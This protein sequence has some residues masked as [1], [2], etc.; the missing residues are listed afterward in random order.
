[1][2]LLD[3]KIKRFFIPVNLPTRQAGRIQNGWFVLLFTSHV[4][5]LLL[6]WIYLN[7]Q[8]IKETQ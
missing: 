1:M 2:N 3:H 8:K 5:Q 6:K 7:R 4:S